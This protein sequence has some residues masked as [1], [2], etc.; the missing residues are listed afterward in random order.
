MIRV[1]FGSDIIDAELFLRDCYPTSCSSLAAS[2]TTGTVADAYRRKL[3]LP[4]SSDRS[5]GTK[6]GGMEPMSEH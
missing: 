2:T 6:I 3:H 4:Y 1:G 5:T